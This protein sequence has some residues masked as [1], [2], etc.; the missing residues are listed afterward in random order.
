MTTPATTPAVTP[1]K[2]IFRGDCQPHDNIDSLPAAPVWRQFAHNRADRGAKHLIREEEVTAI[3]AAIYLRR[4]LL[5]TG[6]PGTGKSSLAYAIAHELKLGDVLVWPITSRST[7]T[8]GLYRYDAID[9][10]QGVNLSD[11]DKSKE[12]MTKTRHI[13]N[14][15]HLGP[16]G[17]AFARSKAKKPTVLLI[18]ELDKSDIDLPND[19]LHLFEEG[20]FEIPELSREAGKDS[21][22]NVGTHQSTEATPVT[23]GRVR[24]EEFPIVL[25]TSNDEREFPPA[26]LRRCLRLD[27]REPNEDDLARIVYHRLGIKTSEDAQIQALLA[28]FIKARR[29]EKK[30]LATDQLLNAAYLVSQKLWDPSAE[31]LRTLIMREL[32]Q[33]TT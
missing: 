12:G 13:G 9:R 14:Y 29:D 20:E 22:V 1:A 6:K 16:L 15:I 31:T 8:H 11:S 28:A 26:F 19:L 10:L 24:C 2:R 18:D 3:N 33:S 5:V 27:I 25:I 23:G 30:Q 4:P 21:V 7:L 17:T 32:A